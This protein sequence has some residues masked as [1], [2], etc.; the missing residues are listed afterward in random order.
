MSM[1]AYLFCIVPIARKIL[2]R[3]KIV[4]SP[5]SSPMRS[6]KYSTIVFDMSG[7]L[8]DEAY[9]FNLTMKIWP[10]NITALKAL[11]TL[12]A[13]P[14]TDDF[15]RGIIDTPTYAEK[16]F[17]TYGFD[18]KE[19]TQAALELPEQL[20]PIPAGI[21]M[22]ESAK[23]QGYRLFLLTNIYP[24]VMEKLQAK[25]KFFSLFDGIMASCDVGQIKPEAEIYKSLLAKFAIEPTTALF[26]DDRKKN[27]TAAAQLGIDGIICANPEKTLRL[28][29]ANNVLSAT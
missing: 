25:H 14:L 27:V 5:L 24:N 23:K 7:V 20:P 1:F 13:N 18:P 2:R 22:L 4:Q 19:I 16:V 8:L 29:I 9:A 21:K 17:K 28:L 12:L 10:G 26:I 15:N 11:K 3:T 6:K